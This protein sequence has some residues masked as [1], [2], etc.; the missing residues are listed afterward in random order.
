MGEAARAQSPHTM[1]AATPA[2]SLMDRLFA[3][4]LP[5]ERAAGLR[6][7]SNFAGICA[8]LV[9]TSIAS[10]CRCPWLPR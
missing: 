5:R 9:Y 4:V 2:T 10:I 1:A 8:A 6:L 7:L 3:G